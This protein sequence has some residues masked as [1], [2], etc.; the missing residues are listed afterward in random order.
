MTTLQ[1]PRPCGVD[2]LPCTSAL[3]CI[4]S[5]GKT[6]DLVFVGKPRF[7][8]EGAQPRGRPNGR[9]LKNPDRQSRQNA[10]LQDFHAGT[11]LHPPPAPSGRRQRFLGPPP[12]QRSL[13]KY[14]QGNG[15]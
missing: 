11:L 7:W 3:I 8:Q 2:F 15:C 1:G 14:C 10:G 6:N 12:E 4:A 13:R 9:V 5:S